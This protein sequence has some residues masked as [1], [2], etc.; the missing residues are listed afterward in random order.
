MLIKNLS[1][2]LEHKIWSANKNLSFH[3]FKVEID[4]YEK[5]NAAHFQST[6]RKD[7]HSLHIFAV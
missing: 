5:E 2:T 6:D 4:K 3:G 7:P 1:Y